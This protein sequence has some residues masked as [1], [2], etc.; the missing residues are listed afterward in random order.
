MALG[1]GSILTD[2]SS[3]TPAAVDL[4]VFVSVF[5]PCVGGQDAGAEAMAVAVALGV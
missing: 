5:S 2:D 4:P 1:F 3:L